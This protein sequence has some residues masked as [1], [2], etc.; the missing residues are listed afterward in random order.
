MNPD[1]FPDVTDPNEPELP[2]G[3]QCTPD[4]NEGI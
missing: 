1:D 2:D 3:W 4:D